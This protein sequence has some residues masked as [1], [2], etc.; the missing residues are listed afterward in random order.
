MHVRVS[1]VCIIAYYAFWKYASA[2]INSSTDVLCRS[3]Y[4]CEILVEQMKWVAVGETKV[5]PF[6]Q[7]NKKDC[8]AVNAFVPYVRHILCGTSQRSTRVKG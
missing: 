2:Y 6:I 7:T 4:K 8:L 3:D 5:L 1:E